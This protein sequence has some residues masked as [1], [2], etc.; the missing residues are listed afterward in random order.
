MLAVML[1]IYGVPSISYGQ[2]KAPAVTPG[3]TN[4]S[5]VVSFSDFF[6]AYDVNAYQIQLRRKTPQGDWI[7]ACAVV[8][9]GSRSGGNLSDLPVIG[10]F[11]LPGSRAGGGNVNFVFTNLKPGTTYEA[12]YRDTNLSECHENPPSPD[13]WSAI[14]EGTTHLVAPPRVEFVDVYL[15]RVVR[16]ALRLDTGGEHIELL[17]IPEVPLA[18]LTELNATRDDT[19]DTPFSESPKIVNL[20]GLEHASQLTGLSLGKHG[21]RDI[22]PLAQLTQLTELN[23]EYNQIHDITPLMQLTQLNGLGLGGNQISDITPLTGL[24]Q[25]RRLYLGGNQIIDITPLTGL[26]QLRRLYLGG[27]QIIDIG[28]LT[29][30][31]LTMLGLNNNKIR[32]ITSLSQWTQWGQLTELNLT[33]NQIGDITPLTHLA[34]SQVTELDLSHN[35][36]VDVTP[37]AQLAGSSVTDLDLS[38]NQI[39]DVTP[40]A[41]LAGSSVTDLDLS[42]NQIKNVAPLAELIQLEDLDLWDNPIENTFPLR[43][44][45]DANPDLWIDITISTEEVPTLSVSTLQPLTGITL[46]GAVVTLTLSSGAFHYR[47]SIRDALTISGIPG[48]GLGEWHE[49]ERVSQTEIEIKLTFKGSNI[50]TDSILTL[51]VAPGGNSQL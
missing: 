21:I 10:I 39:S 16:R 29:Q 32:D 49:I 15:A 50:T 42:Y 48:I 27:N 35:R 51:T 7:T 43:A 37:L 25:L 47:S 13:P 33:H 14:A 1:L 44:L 23:L 26:T 20:T 18:K 28:P 17:K 36:I 2:G 3:E 34:G 24:T 22:T 8:S 40:L 9:A 11:F 4:T 38:R 46:D 6:Y 19:F 41:Q 5:L 45:L 12:R 31:T 30:L